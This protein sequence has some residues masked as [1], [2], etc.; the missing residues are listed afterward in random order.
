[1]SDINENPSPA[2]GT[3]ASKEKYSVFNAMVDIIASPMRA[4]DEIREHT[5]WL[6]IPLFLGLGV[7]CASFTYYFHWVDFDWLTEQTIQ[8]MPVE[9]RAEAAPQVRSFMTPILSSTFAITAIVVVSL[10]LYTLFAAYYHLVAKMST[11]AELR[12]GQWFSLNVWASF[13]GIF[14]AIAPFVVILLAD[15]NQLG[16]DQLTPLSLNQLFIGAEP[17]DPWFNWANSTNLLQLWTTALAGL[18]FARWTDSSLLKGMLVAF[19][20]LVLIYGI[21]AALV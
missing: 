2:S 5:G 18:G 3:P 13:P 14:N 7:S 11:Q 8:A 9:Q 16:Q 15:S 6:W 21:W 12:Y 19:I 4:L 20:P 10:V 17:G 1:M